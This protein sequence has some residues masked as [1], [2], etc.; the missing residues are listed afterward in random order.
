MLSRVIFTEKRMDAV[1]R[2]RTEEPV[3]ELD[4]SKPWKMSDVVLLVEDERLYVHRNVLVLWSPVFEKMLTS[5]YREK[6]IAE[7]RLPGKEA[8][9]VKAFL[10]MMYP[11]A[12]EQITLDNYDAILNLA[13][14][15]QIA[16]IV[17]KCECFLVKK[18]HFDA[19]HRSNKQQDPISLLILAQ[20][21]ELKELTNACV[22]FAARYNLKELKEHEL[23]DS[24][25]PENYTHIL[26]S[27]VARMDRDC[28]MLPSEET[29]QGI[30]ERGIKKIDAIV[31]NLLK[32]ASHKNFVS[33]RDLNTQDDTVEAYLL[34]LKMD[35]TH[36]SCPG[37][38][39]SICPGL[40]PVSSLLRQLKGTLES[41]TEG[42]S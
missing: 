37:M 23:C 29:L 13:H 12:D 34:A 27:V 7:I 6:S 10:M 33:G 8:E 31:K 1:K 25:E 18:L 39:N 21:Y 5:A 38:C 36:H 30:K 3:A 42:K 35:N 17:E 14:E 41:L 2:A 4:F 20:N 40:S 9:N 26:E 15:Y 24:I 16:S 11:P 32:H 19:L 22:K 28:V